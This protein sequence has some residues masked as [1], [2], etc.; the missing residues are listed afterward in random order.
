LLLTADDS[1]TGRFSFCNAADLPASLWASRNVALDGVSIAHAAAGVL[2]GIFGLRFL[3]VTLLVLGWEVGGYLLACGSGILGDLL[4]PSL[5]DV[6]L[7]FA[8][9]T[10][11]RLLRAI[12]RRRS[13]R[14]LIAEAQAEAEAVWERETGFGGASHLQMN[15]HLQM[16]DARAPILDSATY[17]TTVVDSAMHLELDDHEARAL[18]A[19]LDARLNELKRY[20]S[21]PDRLTVSGDS[22][23]AIGILESLLNRLPA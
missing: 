15:D 22:W 1:M 17:T 19:A 12:D 3:T 20:A 16:S 5:S 14:R 18:R 10:I 9:W 8:G 6:A 13:E 4:R 23:A 2:F 21:R 11:G 7:T